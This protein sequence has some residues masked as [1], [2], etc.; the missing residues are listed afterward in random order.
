MT[1]TGTL[2]DAGAMRQF[3]RF[4]RATGLSLDTILDDELAAIAAASATADR[5]PA[6]G[7]VDIMQVCSAV[8]RRPDLGVAFAIWGNIR[9]WGPL[10]LLW[11]HCPT[12]AEALRVNQRYLHVE[13]GA[14]GGKGVLEGDDIALC[15]FLLVPARYGGSQFI[16]GT[17]TLEMRVARMLLGE[18]WSAVRLELEGPA[19]DDT[20]YQ[21]SIYRCPIE[22]GADRNALVIRRSD[23]DRPSRNGNAHMLAYLERHLEA[24]DRALP[25][26]LVQEVE[27]VVVANL[28]GGRT[29][30]GR[31]ATVLA[32]SPRTLQRRLAMEGTSFAT[33]LATARRRSA[34]EYFLT[35]RR[36][37]LI[38]LAHRLG[39]GDASAVSRFL[40]TQ[41]GI[42]ARALAKGEKGSIPR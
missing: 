3:V 37:N 19:P 31:V 26:D 17:L 33:I 21:R 25:V 20:R 36:P 27:Q 10:S 32:V 5:I 22:Y 8:A 9:G 42:G 16:Q 38:H 28:A 34:D 1:A 6:H 23:L 39:Y 13:T 35:D 24:F 2:A 12:L 7:I 41:L 11:D 15:Q 4:A 40:R 29:T 30:L 18:D 14:L